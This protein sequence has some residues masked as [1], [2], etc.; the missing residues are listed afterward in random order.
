M[1]ASLLAAVLL[2]PFLVGAVV[3]C[4]DD[5]VVSDCTLTRVGWDADDAVETSREAE[6]AGRWRQGDLIGR[7]AGPR[8]VE[9]HN[10]GGTPVALAGYRV[11]P[12]V[13]DEEL[14]LE[15]ATPV[16]SSHLPAGGRVVVDVARGPDDESVALIAPDRWIVLVLERDAVS[17]PL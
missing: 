6:L 10:V 2:G 12:L 9:L 15:V 4:G 17:R 14:D 1:K 8:T 3:S 11:A 7:F 13:G 5:G 16:P